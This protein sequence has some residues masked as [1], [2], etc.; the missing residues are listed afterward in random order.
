[1]PRAPSPSIPEK[2]FLFNALKQSLRLD[3]RQA[4][5]MREPKLSFGADLGYVECSLGKTRLAGVNFRYEIAFPIQ[6]SFL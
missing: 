6:L 1:M 3:G 2:E 4:L 5:E